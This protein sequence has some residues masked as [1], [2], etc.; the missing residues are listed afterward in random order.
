[1][2]TIRENIA[3]NIRKFR[4][5]KGLNVDEVGAV[6][7]KSGK[8]VSAWE[9]G[10]GQPDADTLIKLCRLFNVDIADF[11]GHE[12]GPLPLSDSE[13]SLVTTFRAID[14]NGRKAL[15]AAANGIAEAFPA[16]RK[17]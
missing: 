5:T 2:D 15:L 3:N 1:M 13:R 12:S 11:Y 16:T 4:T 9:V 6:V 7:G 10:R 8:T 14:E 17:E